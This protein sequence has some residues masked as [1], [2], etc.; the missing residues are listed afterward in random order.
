[1]ERKVFSRRGG[2]QQ[3]SSQSGP[4]SFPECK[5]LA[6]ARARRTEWLQLQESM[7]VNIASSMRPR[8]STSRHT[9]RSQPAAAR[10]PTVILGTKQTLKERPLDVIHMVENQ[11]YDTI[12]AEFGISAQDL[13]LFHIC[14]LE[15]QSVASLR[16][17]FISLDRDG[18]GEL[19]PD[20]VFQ[21]LKSTGQKVFEA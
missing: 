3:E 4:Q 17:L 16:S 1:M 5:S 11:E 18:G 7:Q 21:A 19:G 20:E 12:L 14:G 15:P 6:D 8:E 13:F 2:V 10:V 9:L